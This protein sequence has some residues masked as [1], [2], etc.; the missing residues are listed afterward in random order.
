MKQCVVHD[1]YDYKLKSVVV[2]VN[3][4]SGK[5]NLKWMVDVRSQE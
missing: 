2:I 3:Y 1:R 4:Y 5:L